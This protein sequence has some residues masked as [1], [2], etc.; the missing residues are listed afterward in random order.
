MQ[1]VPNCEI[2]FCVRHHHS[3]F[4][5]TYSGQVYKDQFWKCAKASTVSYFNE[6][7]QGMKKIKQ[8]AFNWLDNSLHPRFWSR[9]YFKEFSKCDVVIN[10]HSE[11]F[12]KFILE[13]RDKPIIAMLE[14]IRNLLMMRIIR[15]KE[16]MLKDKGLIC[17]RIQKKLDDLCLLTNTYIVEQSDLT[18]Y[19]VMGPV[20]QWVVDIDLKTCAC[21]VWQLS[22]LPCV[23]ACAALLHIGQEPAL[24]IHPCYSK[25]RYIET[26]SNCIK[27]INGSDLW[28]ECDKKALVPP[29]AQTQVGRKKKKRNKSAEELERNSTKLS[30]KKMAMTC[31]LCGNGGHNKRY[32]FNFCNFVFLF[33]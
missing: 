13:A 3:N 32:Y 7:M 4:R 27:A 6:C 21:R 12:N 19:Q 1:I 17:P 16:N 25:Q 29:I 11:V 15:N 26:Y 5:K 8:G 28:P 9:S 14:C 20:M 10:N 2:R 23:H 31:S 30:R 33:I 18:E 24:Y 22:G